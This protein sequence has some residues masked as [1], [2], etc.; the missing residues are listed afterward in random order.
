MSTL[1]CDAAQVDISARLD[2][3]LEPDASL[4][5]DQ[6][7]AD[8]D[9]CRRAEERL[10]RARR[11]IRIHPV[12]R[13]PDLTDRILDAVAAEGPRLRRRSEWGT[14]VRLGAVAAAVAAL[15]LAGATLS[16]HGNRADVASAGEIASGIR[17]AARSLATYRA[18]Y[19]I[20]ER[21]WNPKVDV[22]KFSAEVWFDAPEKLRLLVS[23]FTTYP[24]RTWPRNDVEVVANPRTWWIREPSECPPAALPVCSIRWGPPTENRTVVHRQPF[25]GTTRVPTDVIV[26][27]ETIVASR[28]F[29]VVGLARVAGRESYHVSLPYREAV[30]LVGAL[31]P[32][33]SWRPFSP[34]DHVQLWLDRD[35]WFPLEF[36]VIAS[37]SRD[38]RLWAEQQGLSDR[39]GETLLNVTAATFDTPRGFGPE[40][41]SA[42]TRGIVK[43]A[44]FTPR[45]ALPRWAPDASYVA[46]LDPYRSGTT[47]TGQVVSAYSGGSTWLKITSERTNPPKPFYPATAEQVALPAN[48]GWGYYEPSSAELGR[49]LDVFGAHVH[50]HLES[51]LPR[52]EILRVGASLG[53]RGQP[54][55]AR[56]HAG[57]GTTITR[58]Y[59]SDPYA[60][61]PYALEPSWVPDGYELSTSL[62][63]EGPDG[64]S[65]LTAYY[66]SPE[67]DYDGVGI[68][69]TQ[70]SPVRLLTPSSQDYAHVVVRGLDGRW[71]PETGDLEWLDGDTY[72]SI[73]VPSFDLATALRIA[74][75]MR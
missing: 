29:R 5:L 45:R 40:T 17:S 31:Q 24:D 56:I 10:A 59:G 21:G 30:P 13:V 4:A 62:E 75:G 42:P 66:R 61:S 63:S 73:E 44:G 70:S 33:G 65:T 14:R 69:V 25:D 48:A 36:K 19:D 26:P 35:A 49:R 1:R 71:S 15:V 8:C 72:R 47:S 27:L 23:D 74:D 9:V 37:G 41:F 32:G 46:G 2:G 20:V 43:D 50:A 34:L 58:L 57:D 3:E 54:A 64:R 12:E 68:K 53:L 18:S 55:P 28:D 39:P 52:D 60:G 38:R 22:R 16:H 7:L 6:H 11:A 67:A 51:N